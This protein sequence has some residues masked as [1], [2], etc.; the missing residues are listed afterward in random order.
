MLLL[1]Q[2]VFGDIYL[3]CGRCGYR[4]HEGSNV[5][6]HLKKKVCLKDRGYTRE[7][8]IGLSKAERK[9]FLRRITSAKARKKKKSLRK[10]ILKINFN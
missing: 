2:E 7:D 1:G 6:R 5:R 9:K 4:S 8:L 3:G 10:H